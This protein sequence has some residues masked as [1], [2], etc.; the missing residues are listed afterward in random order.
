MMTIRKELQPDSHARLERVVA[1]SVRMQRMI[2]QLLDVA[3]AHLPGGLEV[4]SGEPRDLVPVVQAI[5][6]EVNA[7]RPS[8]SIE[9]VTSPAFA[10]VDVERFQQAV[11]GA[12]AAPVRFTPTRVPC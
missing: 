3:R 8:R 11:S 1:S 9:L 5:V 10:R 2:E 6:G 12:F 7:S 4:Q